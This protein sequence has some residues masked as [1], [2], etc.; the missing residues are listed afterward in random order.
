MEIK[1]KG[2]ELEVK[3]TQGKRLGDLVVTKTKLIWCKGNTT[4]ANG[5]SITWE[6]FIEKMEEI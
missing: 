3:T 5:H 6:K 1:T 2:I 4:P